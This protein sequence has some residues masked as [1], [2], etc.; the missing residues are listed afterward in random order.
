MDADVPEH[1]GG[2]SDTDVPIVERVAGT[3]GRPGEQAIGGSRDGPESWPDT[4]GEISKEHRGGPRI[5]RG[6]PAEPRTDPRE[7]EQ[8]SRAFERVAAPPRSA[9]RERA[10]QLVRSR[11]SDEG[12]ETRAGP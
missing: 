12:R 8:G 5:G 1:S 11:G 7:V 10:A 9:L 2:S 6:H 4:E 3:I